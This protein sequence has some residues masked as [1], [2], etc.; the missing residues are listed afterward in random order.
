MQR[1]I[2]ATM[3]ALLGACAGMREAAAQGVSERFA[4]GARGELDVYA[5]ANA[6]APA[7]V[8]VFFYGGGWQFGDRARIAPLAETLA[9]QGFVVVVPDYRVFPE[10]RF[11]GFIE[12]AAAAIKW[13]QDNVARFG[14]DPTRIVLAGHSAGGH[15][16]TLVALDPSY[17]AYAG[18]DRS[19]IRGVVGMSAP[20]YHPPDFRDTRLCEIF[21]SASD[22]RQVEPM[23]FVSADDPPLL[24]LVGD[25]DTA[26]PP[27]A[28]MLEAATGA[29]ARVESRTYVG[30]DHG[31]TYRAFMDP[32]IAPVLADV[33]EFARR[34]TRE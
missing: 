19:A 28:P 20:Y 7:P 15:I 5:A 9:A 34:V 11:P 2:L 13:T 14:G 29:G 18:F 25:Q 27:L 23:H 17:A 30:V 21:C 22:W 8:I 10:V 26:V 31:G 16:A 32:S 12:D 6:T 4:P 33:T 3:L 24:L 1:A